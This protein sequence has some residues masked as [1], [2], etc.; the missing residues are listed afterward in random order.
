[1]SIHQSEMS[2]RRSA[3]IHFGF[4]FDTQHGPLQKVQVRKDRD[5]SR[6]S[7]LAQARNSPDEHGRKKI[8][9]ATIRPCDVHSS[10][11][12]HPQMTANYSQTRRQNRPAPR[13]TVVCGECSRYLQDY[14]Y[15]RFLQMHP[16][17]SPRRFIVCA[18]CLHKE[19]NSGPEY[20]DHLDEDRRKSR[21]I[22]N[23]I[24]SV[25]RCGTELST[26]MVGK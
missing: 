19:N 13:T 11:A 10:T 14:D 15:Q 26:G 3:R 25:N 21:R 4:H 8:N 23:W 6:I 5:R 7:E 1:M 24:Q 16:K 2:T 22:E 17:L 20:V 9:Y 12:G 18:D